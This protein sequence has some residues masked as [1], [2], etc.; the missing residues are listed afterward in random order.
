MTARG[1]LPVDQTYWPDGTPRREF[2]KQDGADAA[3]TLTDPEDERRRALVAAR[4]IPGVKSNSGATARGIQ[5]AAR[6]ADYMDRIYDP[7]DVERDPM[8]E[9]FADWAERPR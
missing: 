7:S 3:V 5:V 8:V 4:E 6:L 9:A 2:P 1:Y